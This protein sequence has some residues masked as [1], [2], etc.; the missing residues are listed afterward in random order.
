MNWTCKKKR[1]LCITKIILNQSELKELLFIPDVIW[2]LTS[3]EVMV[4][5]RIY[6]IAIS[7]IDTLKEKEVDLKVLAENGVKIF[8]HK[9]LSKISFMLIC[10]QEIYSWILLILKTTLHGYRL[11]NY[12]YP[13]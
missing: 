5:E 11:C 2:E 8:L 3:K 6:G 9:C 1:K 10:I 12:G 7:E 4:V 13:L